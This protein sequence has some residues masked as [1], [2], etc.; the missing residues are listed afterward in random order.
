MDNE[1]THVIQWLEENRE[2]SYISEVGSDKRLASI[3]MVPITLK[4]ND[5]IFTPQAVSIGP[6]HFLKP[7]LAEMETEKSLIIVRAVVEKLPSD[8]FAPLQKIRDGGS[9]SDLQDD[10]FFGSAV[11]RC[12]DY[13]GDAQF[14]QNLDQEVFSRMLFRDASFLLLFLEHH[15]VNPQH[16]KKMLQPQQPS[17]SNNGDPFHDLKSGTGLWLGVMKDIFKL[18]NQIP[19]S[20]LESLYAFIGNPNQSFKAFLA[21]V[22]FEYS[23][24]WIQPSEDADLVSNRHLLHCIHASVYRKPPVRAGQNPPSGQN[25][26]NGWSPFTWLKNNCVWDSGS[27][28]DINSK[29]GYTQ[30]QG[31]EVRLPNY[32]KTAV[33]CAS[34]LRKAGVK[35]KRCEGGIEQI[36]FDKSQSTLYLPVLR[37]GQMTETIIRN[38][39]A[40]ELCTPKI[41]ENAVIGFT[42]LL[43]ELTQDAKDAEV[44][45]TNEIFVSLGVSDDEIVEIVRNLSRLTWKPYFKPVK[46]V[47]KSLKTYYKGSKSKVLWSEFLETYC[48]KP[49]VFISALAA[50]VLLVMTAVQVFCLFYTCNKNS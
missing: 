19:L 46:D 24:L 27:N 47:T 21:K 8:F 29:E 31:K 23:P 4:E 18:E 34:E 20:T 26:I 1:N 12:R 22:C 42:R 32:R 16:K 49:W 35:F 5:C 13:Y 41:E 6:Y 44:L 7:H 25:P 43:K 37:I 14:L 48:S 45:R 17:A 9:L 38:L 15:V 39:I 36:R 40:F 11:L 50:T 28:S 2:D 10:N 33:P 30:L 3:F